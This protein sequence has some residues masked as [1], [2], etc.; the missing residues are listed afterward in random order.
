MKKRN[1]IRIIVAVLLIVALVVIHFRKPGKINGFE[2]AVTTINGIDIPE[3]TRIIALGEATHGN[4]EFQQLKLEVFRELVEKTNVRAIIL[5]GDVGGC[6]IA[7]A[8]IQGNEDTAEAVTKRLG[9]RIYRT[10]QMCEL[11]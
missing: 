7:N 5:E 9:Y 8:Y 11:V 4:K 2:S 6:A 10:D 3:G 1:I